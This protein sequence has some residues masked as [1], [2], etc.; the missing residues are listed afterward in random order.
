MRLDHQK[1]RSARIDAGVTQR[2]A[3]DE[4]AVT[5]KTVRSWESGVHPVPS[6]HLATLADLYGVDDLWSLFDQHDPDATP[7]ANGAGQVEPV[8]P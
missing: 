2:V 5:E 6:G 3:A 8:T 1:L 7:A 4:C